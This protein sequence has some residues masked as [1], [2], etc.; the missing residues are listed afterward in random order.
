MGEVTPDRVGRLEIDGKEVHW[1]YHGQGEREAVC[2][3]NGL[4]MHTRA[5]E[6]DSSRRR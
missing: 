4:A 2:L 6:S 5:W 1:E 3:L